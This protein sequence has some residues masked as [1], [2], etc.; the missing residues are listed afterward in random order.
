MAQRTG[1]FGGS[2]AQT[3][4]ALAAA[5]RP[6]PILTG[7]HHNTRAR[8][9]T[10]TTMTARAGVLYTWDCTHARAPAPPPPTHTHTHTDGRSQLMG[11]ITRGSWGIL[12]A[13]RFF[14]APRPPAAPPADADADA[15]ERAWM[16]PAAVASGAVRYT[17]ENPLAQVRERTR[18]HSHTRGGDACAG[19]HLL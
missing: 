11:E 9:H 19:R 13:P 14:L 15:G 16:W 4:A 8:A 6:S 2:A 5:T 7:E 12:D 3:P 17:R 10:H 18:A 1:G